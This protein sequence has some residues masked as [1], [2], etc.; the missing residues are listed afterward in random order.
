MTNRAKKCDIIE[1]LRLLQKIYKVYKNLIKKILLTK[2]F[3]IKI[4]FKLIS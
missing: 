3:H 4:F 1:Q 2:N